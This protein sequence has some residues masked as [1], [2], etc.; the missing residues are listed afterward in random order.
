M[1]TDDYES[2]RTNGSILRLD[3]E[4]IYSLRH[5]SLLLVEVVLEHT[6][7]NDTRQLLRQGEFINVHCIQSNRVNASR[8]V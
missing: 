5:L 1:S 7:V 8:K 3:P 2:V 6:A 4:G